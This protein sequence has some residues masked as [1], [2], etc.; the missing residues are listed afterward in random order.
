MMVKATY[1]AKTGSGCQVRAMFPDGTIRGD[2]VTFGF[3][4]RTKAQQSERLGKF[5][6]KNR[7]TK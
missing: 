1:I 3:P 6:I 2:V 4:K 7:R 5:I